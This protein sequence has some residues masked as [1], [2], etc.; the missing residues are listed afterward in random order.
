MEVVEAPEYTFPTPCTITV[1]GPS[2]S[3]K[4]TL[5]INGII[6]YRN[7][8]FGPAEVAGVLYFYAEDQPAFDALLRDN[9]GGGGMIIK[10]VKGLP[11]REDFEAMVDGFHGRHFLCVLDD[12]MAEMANSEL[13]QDIFT[14]L[15]HHRMFSCINVQQNLFVQGRAAR[16]QA[17]NSQFYLLTR[18]CCDL[19]QIS[20]LKGLKCFPGKLPSS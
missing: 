3:G 5:L 8:L 18:T 9:E 19:K 7:E 20:L 15:S 10:F 6:E 12:L 13:G 14:K 11:S 17:L 4:T 1:A 2:G 16:S